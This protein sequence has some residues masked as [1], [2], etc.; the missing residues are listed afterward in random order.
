MELQHVTIDNVTIRRPLNEQEKEADNIIRLFNRYFNDLNFNDLSLIKNKYSVYDAIITSGCC[1][2][3][4]T[5]F[6]SRVDLE[7]NTYWSSFIEAKKY[8]NLK[9][10]CT[11]LASPVALYIVEYK[12]HILIF[13]LD[14]KTEYESG[15][16]AMQKN[17]QSK[18]TVEKWIYHLPIL[19]ANYCIEKKT[20]AIMTTEEVERY[21]NEK[22][23]NQ[24]ELN[25][26]LTEK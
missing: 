15:L 10:A 13:I 19:S 17:N 24:D 26:I 11:L 9:M 8:N 3:I 4:I 22:G 23:L 7:A 2:S 1:T 18:Q 20:G 12:N 14:F 16:E 21:L 25:A 6:K 5:E